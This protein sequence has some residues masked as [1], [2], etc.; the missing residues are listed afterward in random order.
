ML[1]I[2]AARDTRMLRM[3]VRLGDVEKRLTLVDPAI[4]G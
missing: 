3:D 2:L 1:N 4:P